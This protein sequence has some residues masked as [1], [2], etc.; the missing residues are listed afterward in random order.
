MGNVNVELFPLVVEVP[1]EP[2]LVPPVQGV[3]GALSRHS[4][5]LTVPVGGPPVALPATTAVSPQ[6]LPTAVALGGR[7]VVLKPG[8]AATKLM[9]QAGLVDRQV[10]GGEVPVGTTKLT[11][12]W[13]PVSGLLTVTV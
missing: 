3:E 5:Q 11:S 1:V 12:W 8:V 13:S 4:V 2:M 7:I 9:V 6:G 10:G